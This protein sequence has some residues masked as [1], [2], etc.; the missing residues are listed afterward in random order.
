MAKNILS[1]VHVKIWGELGFLLEYAPLKMNDIFSGF[2]GIGFLLIPFYWKDVTYKNGIKGTCRKKGHCKEQWIHLIV[3]FS[4]VKIFFYCVHVI[5]KVPSC[6]R[7]SRTYI[8]F[9]GCNTLNLSIFL[10]AF[11]VVWIFV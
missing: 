9:G 11:D 4:S 10:L 6:A 8:K 2:S 5:P 1:Q 3:T 7:F